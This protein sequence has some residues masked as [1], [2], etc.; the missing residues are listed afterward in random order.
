M[1]QKIN[2]AIAL[3]QGAALVT[4]EAARAIVTQ[5]MTLLAQSLKDEDGIDVDKGG[6]N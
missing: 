3:L 1:Q 2:E 6:G 5:A 4:P